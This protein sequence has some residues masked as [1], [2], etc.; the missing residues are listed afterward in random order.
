MAANS[1]RLVWDANTE[2]NLA[3]YRV[4]Y[5]GQSGVHTN[6]TD[7]GLTTNATVFGILPGVMFY[8]VV[9]AYDSNGL[10]SDPSNEV[11][12]ML[13]ALSTPTISAM[14]SQTT[15]VNTPKS[16]GFLVSAGTNAL[17]NLTVTA[18]SSNPSL[19]PAVNITFSG[20]GSS[21]TALIT[22]LPGLTGSALITFTVSAGGVTDSA[23]FSL[24][25]NAAN[26]PPTLAAIAGVT[27]TEDAAASSVS[28][29]GIGAGGGASQPLTVTAVS[30][31]P[32]LIPTPTISYS[33]PA[34]TGSLSFRP[35]ANATGTATISVTVN[36][37]QSQSN[38]VTR[39]FTVTVLPV[40][41][42]PSIA[43]IADQTITQ[44][45]A[46]SLVPFTV[47]DAETPAASLTLAGTSS[48]PTL[49]P[50]NAIVFGGSGAS[51]TVRVTPALNRT[52]AATITVVVSD[53][54][55][56]AT[57]TF[58]VTVSS[59]GNQTP[60]LTALGNLSLNEDAG[61]QTVALTGIASGLT[62]ANPT[63]TVTAASSNPGLIPTPVVT[64]TSPASSG[65]LGFKLMTNASGSA[66]ITV[67]VNNGQSQTNRSF[68]VTVAPVND[69]PTIA[70]IADQTITQNTATS[71]VPFT[72]GDVE[73]PAASLTLTGTSSN[74]SLVPNSAIVFGG[75][76]S[77][78]TVRVTPV[79]NQLG[80]ATITVVVR[81]GTN[82]ATDSFVL[83]V[84]PPNQGPTLAVLGNLSINEDA[85]QQNV[86]LTGISS[87]LTNP[88]PTLTVIAVSSN[89]SLIPTPTVTYTSPAGSGSLSFKAATNASGSATITVTVNNGQSLS[90]RITRSFTVTIVPVN[91]PPTITT[92][93]SQSVQQNVATGLLPFTVGDVET[94]AASLTLTGTSSNPSLLPNSA[95]VF[96]GSTASRTVRVTP[97]LN[98]FGTATITATVRDGTNSTSSTF[99][100]TV[101]AVNLRPTLNALTNLVLNEDAGLQT[102]SLSGISAGST[103]E[104]QTLT[105]SA[106]SSNPSLIPHP[107][108]TYTSPATT[109]TL[110]LKSATN[111]TGS[112][113][114]TVTVNDGQSSS[115]LITRA[116]TVTVN[117]VNDAPALSA[118]PDYEILVNTPTPPIPFTVSDSDNSVSSLTFSVASTNATLVPPGNILVGGSGS[119]RSIRVIPEPNQLGITRITVTAGSAG[120]L[121]ATQ[122]FLLTVYPPN[123]APTISTL[124][125]LV[126]DFYTPL[127]GIRFTVG[128]AETAAS[129]LTIT[130]TSSS[131]LVI[132][133]TNL[134]LAGTGASRTLTVRPVSGQTGAATVS[135][136][137][138]DGRA[139]TK[140]SFRV[141]VQAPKARLLVMKKGAGKVTPDLSTQ[142]LTVGQS[143]TLTAVPEAG[144]VFAGWAGGLRSAKTALTFRMET[145]LLLEASFMTNPF[146]PARG[147]YTGLYYETNEVRHERSGLLT[148]STTDQGKYSGTL[149]LGGRRYTLSGRF[150]LDCHATNSIPRKGTNALTLVFALGSGTNTGRL[151][152]TVTDGL[153]TAVL[154]G[155]RHEFN[156]IT[157]PAPFTGRHTM[158]LPGQPGSATSP[159]GDGYGAIKISSR[160]F[161]QLTAMT[162]DDR[163]LTLSA[164]LSQD[165]T[166][167]VYVPLYKGKG[168]ILG[169]LNFTNRPSDDFTGLLNWA[170]PSL[171][172]SKLYP[173][174]FTNE[175]LAVGSSYLAPATKTNRVI[176]LTNG[177]VVFSGGNLLQN[178]TNAV[179][180]G[181]DSRVANLGNNRLTLSITTSSGLFKGTAVDP[182]SG[183]SKTFRGALVQK[184]N[185][186]SGYF[187]GTNQTGRVYLGR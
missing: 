80:T 149:R 17:T 3:G 77:N 125:N 1:V 141:T 117:P 160:G 75:S 78:R 66:T 52:G 118:I 133:G 62:N 64:Y 18:S 110:Q 22:P 144:Q 16:V 148:V 185:E 124:S 65:T 182:V 181:A 137:V 155:D 142:D 162:A 174:G 140:T 23:S 156:S 53:G 178:F 94:P 136:A 126:T 11:G 43:S 122:T 109:G 35:A 164:P 177:A 96:S 60:S 38:L 81:D 114:I 132:P 29:S 86:P 104:N 168:S 7:V 95:I 97:A 166:C 101:N 72:V 20:T 106:V 90:N 76:G 51:R 82:S 56:S 158:V 145:N 119:E 63:L 151:L 139:V 59:A 47:G 130:V 100:L 165:G 143:Y 147:T 15:V 67:T 25:V 150:D 85:G 24:T 152:G 74:P 129:N 180:M 41:D 170:C 2:T 102:V 105:V 34:S 98:H 69:P 19:V 45:T 71:L 93:A 112:A 30:S 50:N 28:L 37:G 159:G 32:S 127:V 128:D 146:T 121:Q 91:D 14:V 187:R 99:V 48:N 184:R 153:W 8:Y 175:V 33:S 27:V 84:N 89:P 26:I 87:G 39:S 186:G 120:G 83:T 61:S 108:V 169:W 40:N 68:T 172:A 10:E 55:N 57:D 88:N 6:T 138:N 49:V 54:T 79:L 42:A 44:N 115:N 111:A 161:L 173:L 157:N 73:T 58:V 36:D 21:R 183:K 5:G 103:N 92:I 9:T 135:I 107:T 179:A 46:T 4:H 167:P 116:F 154:L 113:T 171:P 12:H 131:Q 13:P 31:N 123:A 163:P 134:V 176:A 70:N